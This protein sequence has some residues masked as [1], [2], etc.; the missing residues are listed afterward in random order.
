MRRLDGPALD[1]QKPEWME[2]LV[3]G[4][5]KEW[6]AA[7]GSKEKRSGYSEELFS[8]EVIIVLLPLLPYLDANESQG[9]LYDF[10]HLIHGKEG[11]C[12]TLQ[13]VQETLE[14]TTI[15]IH[16]GDYFAMYLGKLKGPGFGWAIWNR[17]ALDWVKVATRLRAEEDACKD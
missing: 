7:M 4:L 6:R 10:L 16:Y 15:L 9:M 3:T 8:K 11:L 5:E 13:K 1:G 17:E 12:S 2:D 14:R